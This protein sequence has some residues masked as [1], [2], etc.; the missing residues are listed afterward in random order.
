MRRSLD[1]TKRSAT[2]SRALTHSCSVTGHPFEKKGARRHAAVHP[3][4]NPDAGYLASCPYLERAVP[5]CWRCSPNVRP[6]SSA[7]G[8]RTQSS[9]G[10]SSASAGSV[11]TVTP[12][13]DLPTAPRSARPVPVTSTFSCLFFVIIL[14]LVYYKDRLRG[15][16]SPRWT[17]PAPI[18]SPSH[19]E[20]RGCVS[21]IHQTKIKLALTSSDPAS[22]SPVLAG[23]GSRLTLLT[24]KYHSVSRVRPDSISASS[25]G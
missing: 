13:S 20:K 22:E 23:D 4:L 17:G 19:S 18:Q 25:A 21:F 9:S 6:V 3:P 5:S 10:R 7:L 11:S 12:S 14:N 15:L 24:T 16:H 8:R 1:R 2:Q